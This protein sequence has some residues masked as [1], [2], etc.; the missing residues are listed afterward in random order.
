MSGGMKKFKFAVEE[1]V[2]GAIS[3]FEAQFSAGKLSTDLKSEALSDDHLKSL[4]GAPS[5]RTS[6]IKR[7]LRE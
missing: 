7:W 1:L 5:N 2:T 3:A 4:S 6:S